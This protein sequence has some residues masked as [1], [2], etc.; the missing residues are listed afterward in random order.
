MKTEIGE[1]GY[2]EHNFYAED[3]DIFIPP[4]EPERSFGDYTPGRYAW[5]LTNIKPLPAPIPAKGALGLWDWEPVGV[6]L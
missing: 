6:E 1:D 3:L 2:L 5:I 4:P